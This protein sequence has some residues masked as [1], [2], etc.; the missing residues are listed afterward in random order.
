[1][2]FLSA[3]LQSGALLRFTVA[4]TFVL[5]GGIG[6]AVLVSRRWGFGAATFMQRATL[7]AVS[8]CAVFAALSTTRVFNRVPVFVA[9]P[10]APVPTAIFEPSAIPDTSLLLPS[11]EAK[12]DL[13]TVAAASQIAASPETTNHEV[14][15]PV[16]LV[17]AWLIGAMFC[18]VR[19]MVGGR[20]LRGL[21]RGSREASPVAVS[22]V[23]NAARL[24]QVAPPLVRTSQQVTSP[25]VAGVWRPVLYLPLAPLADDTQS[26]VL[27][28][29]TAHLARQD[30]RWFA[31]CRIAA[32]LLWW[33]P[34]IH[35]LGREM[36]QTAEHACDA[37]A[38]QSGM[39]ARDYAA[40]L[41]SLS[42]QTGQRRS[43]VV[44]AGIGNFRSEVGRRIAWVLYP[45]PSRRLSLGTRAGLAGGVVL[46]AAL[47]LVFV[48]QRAES[49]P[50]PASS[51]SEADF[52][53]IFTASRYKRGP[54]NTQIAVVA[55]MDFECPACQRAWND[56]V[57][58]YGTEQPVRLAFRH[59]PLSVHPHARLAARIA[60]GV[61][62]TGNSKPFWSAC[63][64]LFDRF[65][66]LKPGDKAPVLQVRV[67]VNGKNVLVNP[68]TPAVDRAIDAD[69]A[70]VKRFG[71]ASAPTFW[72]YNR[73][74]QTVTV[75]IGV[76]ELRAAVANA[77]SVYTK[78]DQ[79]QQNRTSDM[80]ARMQ[81]LVTL[82]ANKMPIR[83]ALNAVLRQAGIPSRI[84][85]N[86]DGKITINIEN[87]KLDEAV[88]L[89][90]RNATVPAGARYDSGT[91]IV[92]PLPLT[93][94]IQGRVVYPDG[95]P[96]SG[97]PVAANVLSEDALRNPD[98]DL[99]P[100]AWGTTDANGD[101]R[102]KNLGPFRYY[103]SYVSYAPIKSGT[104][105]KLAEDVFFSMQDSAPYVDSALLVR[106]IP[107]DALTIGTIKL[108]KGG[109][110]EGT[111]TERGGN[112][113]GGVHIG[114]HNA[115]YPVECSQVQ[116]TRTGKAGHFRMRVAPG[117]N[118]VYVAQSGF[119]AKDVRVTVEGPRLDLK[120]EY[121][122][123]GAVFVVR[124]GE[125]RRIRFI[126]QN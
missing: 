113:I 60:E 22:Q 64:R 12:T 84:D 51:V 112:P 48:G 24:A 41:L 36:A 87:V 69:L 70:V 107:G 8:L 95:T 80:A 47:G 50:L 79:A 59:L 100:A 17:G 86:V 40:L 110:I 45:L 90:A 7:C 71:V 53:R 101:F 61:G 13:A 56:T 37:A 58:Y 34:L 19:L 115:Q 30:V 52:F 26:A 2:S 111:V 72:V 63:G 27:A 122:S 44:C 3:V 109:F 5:A 123:G 68:N 102:L 83:D 49:L 66:Q 94:T 74:T 23:V 77:P 10:T 98:A 126:R 96:A 14:S 35:V 29:E 88:R 104:P 6:T 65:S 119:D 31:A 43:G 118:H 121:G 15:T 103:V 1:M 78:R 42:E 4:V 67:T 92:A 105:A 106:P 39:T 99:V 76:Q 120:P 21:W 75:A 116:A 9:L 91:C 108:K 114:A 54:E 73:S 85:P 25:F 81:R 32:A 28:H 124:E 62:Q 89:L 33:H 125:T 18:L 38:V 11:A 93:G 117:E 46:L 55:F 97:V 16:V 82:Y 57:Q 20:Y